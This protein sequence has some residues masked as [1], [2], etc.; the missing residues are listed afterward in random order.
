[1]KHIT[2]IYFTMTAAYFHL[3]KDQKTSNVYVYV[4]TQ[5]VRYDNIIRRA[6]A[7]GG[8]LCRL[9]PGGSLSIPTTDPTP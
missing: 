5:I 9:T 1:M 7:Y 6:R 8:S 3:Y 4:Y 2:W